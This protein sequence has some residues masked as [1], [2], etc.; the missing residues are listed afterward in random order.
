MKLAILL[1]FIVLIPLRLWGQIITWDPLYVT[2][3]DAIT[4]YYDASR[5]NAGLKGYTG[6][7]YAHTGIITSRS[8][9]PYDWKYVKTGWG[10]NTQQ[11]RLER[12][13]PELY[14]L[15]IQPDIR[16]YYNIQSGDSVLKLAF[17]FRS[18]SS[19][20][21]EGKTINEGD[22]FLPLRQSVKIFS[23]EQQPLFLN[24]N[25]TLQIRAVGSAGTTHLKRF[26]AGNFVS[27]VSNDTLIYALPVNESGKTRLKIIAEAETGALAADSI[28]FLVNPPVPIA[29]LPPNIGE[30]I[31]YLNDHSVILSLFAPNKHSVYLLGDFNHWE[32]DPRFFMQRTP[33]DS[34]Y[35]LEI[36]GLTP[37]IEYAYQYLIDGNLRI[38][39]PYTAKVLDPRHDPD[40]DVATYPNLK[41]YP[42][43][44]TDGIVSVL[45]TAQVPYEWQV[46]QF[47]RPAK[48]DLVIYELL[49]RDFVA[50][51]NYQTLIDTLDYLERLGVNAVELM[52]IC[53]F[54]GNESWGY[55]PSFYFAPDKYYGPQKDLKRFIDACHQRGLAV[56]LDL[57]LNH[58][59][60]QS[61]LV[62]LYWDAAQN[63]PAAE[64]PWYNQS[65][66][67]GALS[68]GY[69]F[70]HESV[71]TQRFV[72]RV[73]RYWL[74][75]FHVDG[76]RFDFTKG[77]TNTAG[78][79][80][81]YDPDRIRILKRMAD[82][83]WKFD[84]TAYVI[85]EHW[86]PNREEAELADY[87]MLLWGNLNYNYNEA[88]MGWHE[89]GKSD[90]SWGSYQKRGWAKPHLIT[91]ME[92]H[93]E[94]RL[95]YKNKRWGNASGD[96]DVKNVPTALNRIKLA[97]A[98][99]FTI[100]S[101][102]MI[103]Q[104]GELGYDISIDY[105]GRTG[106]KP[107]R[108]DYWQDPLRQRLY[109]TMC[110][111][112]Q[113]KK[114]Y[115]VFR[116]SDFQ[117]NVRGAT[118]QIHLNHE[119]MAV[120]IVGNF[121]V[122]EREINPNFQQAGKW[123]DFFSGD[124]LLVNDSGAPLMLLPGAF[125]LYS[126][127]KLPT[128]EGGIVNK[129]NANERSRMTDYGLFQNY[130]NSFN[131][132]TTITFEN[133]R[134]EQVTLEIFNVRGQKVRTLLNRQLPAGQHCLNWTGNNETGAPLG[135]GIYFCRLRYGETHRQCKMVLLR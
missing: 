107:I 5:G 83:I 13:G 56:I 59:Y 4:V 86:C 72:D 69:D 113:L 120:T 52:P 132:E 9:A 119:S 87:G 36:N 39:D 50:S 100:P 55:N 30:G 116:T 16:T 42:F 24:L 51:H 19:P 61:P 26:V 15:I 89:E 115:P 114:D 77:F 128:P 122:I 123:Y 78:S 93:D 95:M 70:N 11:T 20:F 66:P 38:A 110:A 65:A 47:E 25:D 31:H 105:N 2:E 43:W 74:E 112:I 91:Y 60:G 22:I 12:I 37:Q 34:I 118:K 126:T 79:G 33:N 28:Y 97:S 73:N 46:S 90:F 64:N 81:I 129:I 32:A 76:F 85:L 135:S 127:V 80:D 111:L 124:S 94:E 35:W 98:F 121:D 41:T 54:E 8:I 7:V 62:R 88:T 57:V 133:P 125:H 134:F 131:P 6:E 84:S 49:I 108:W 10:E 99:F 45:Q 58:S 102:K 3:D 71:H 48:T 40:I 82:E 1:L 29:E 103:W 17:V 27:Q 109:K 68:W 23:P 106:N 67:P 63:R 117:L 53:E 96:Y 130:P 44:Q 21:R 92:S 104:F 101:P 18:A 14:R 75:E